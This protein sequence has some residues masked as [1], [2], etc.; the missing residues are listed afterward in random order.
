M[1]ILI[2]VCNYRCFGERPVELRIREGVTAILGPNNAGKSTLCKVLFCLRPTFAH[3]LSGSHFAAWSENPVLMATTNHANGHFSG[4]A[5]E[6]ERW[7]CRSSSG[8]FVLKIESAE[9]SFSIAVDL[10]EKVVKE[11]C[12]EGFEDKDVLQI[13]PEEDSN[14]AM[15]T[16]FRSNGE[17]VGANRYAEFAEVMKEIHRRLQP[18][19]TALSKT[20]YLPA[21][22]SVQNVLSQEPHF[23][24]CFGQELFKKWVLVQTSGNP[25]HARYSY[26]LEKKLCQIFGTEDLRINVHQ[27]A[28]SLLVTI[29][30]HQFSL[31]EL[32]NGLA[33]FVA[34]GITLLLDTP[35]FVFMDEPETGLHPQLQRSLVEFVDGLCTCGVIFTTHGVGLARAAADHLYLLAKD[36]SG[37]PK[38]SEFVTISRSSELLGELS[39][40]TYQELGCKKILLVEGR[41][42]VAPFQHWIR[43][44]RIEHEV[45]V[46]SLAGNDGIYKLKDELSEYKRICND[47]AVIIDSEVDSADS[48]IDPRRLELARVC[49]EQAVKCLILKRRALENY[50]PTSAVSVVHGETLEALGPYEL[51]KDKWPNH[52]KMKHNQALAA[53]TSIYDLQ[54]TDLHLFLES[55]RSAD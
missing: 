7:A 34:I 29:D 48:P 10:R 27:D 24:L 43:Q 49:K 41:S 19:F 21:T 45:V 12:I 8:P 42:D 13:R 31:D 11:V 1:E 2:S 33:Q 5:P 25:T 28:S 44:L 22:R 23:D 15:I 53:V 9:I 55:L 26:L 6:F 36:Q 30:G 50:F 32:G 37:F 46:F 20:R 17:I 16:R 4:P 38:L 35:S 47:I 40:S 52:S 18:L 39:F 54:G 51:P 3:L 14:T